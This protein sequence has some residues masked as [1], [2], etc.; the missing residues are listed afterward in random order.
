GDMHLTI[1]PATTGD[2]IDIAAVLDRLQADFSIQL[3]RTLVEATVRE[4]LVHERARQVQP[5][6][7]PPRPVTE[8]NVQ[9]ALDRLIQGGILVPQES[10]TQLRFALSIRKGEIYANG[11]KVASLGA[12]LNLFSAG[13]SQ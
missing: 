3:P 7:Q 6:D 1:A 13:S 11:Q 4:R 5:G 2:D 12:L 10:D 9:A 8:S